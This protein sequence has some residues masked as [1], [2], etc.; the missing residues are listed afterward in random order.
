MSPSFFQFDVCLEQISLATLLQAPSSCSL[1]RCYIVRRRQPSIL[2][3]RRKTTAFAMYNGDPPEFL[4][5]EGAEIEWHHMRAERFLLSA[6]WVDDVATGGGRSGY[7]IGLEKPHRSAATADLPFGRKEGGRCR[8]E[9][10]RLVGDSSGS[11]FKLVPG[12]NTWS[13]RRYLRCG[14]YATV[15]AEEET[16]GPVRPSAGSWLTCFGAAAANPPAEDAHPL[17]TAC[18]HP[19][20]S[21]VAPPKASPSPRCDLVSLFRPGPLI[22]FLCLGCRSTFLDR[23]RQQHLGRALNSPSGC[24]T[25]LRSGIQGWGEEETSINFLISFIANQLSPL[26]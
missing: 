20:P 16:R 9:C 2:S 24:R 12:A 23:A 6:K 18:F 17:L 25:L 26:Q 22:S 4:K 10:A 7:S 13:A 21:S 3:G 14:S 19:S 5:K 1:L 11:A 8:N 15:S